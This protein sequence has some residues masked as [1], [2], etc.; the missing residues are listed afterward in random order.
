[1]ASEILSL[2]WND[3]S[4]SVCNSYRDLLKYKDFTN[5]TLATDDDEQIKSHKII[6]SSCSKFF[7]RIL[8]K[9]PHENPLIYLKGAKMYHLKLLM[10]FIYL[11]EVNI[12]NEHVEAF[13]NLAKDLEIQ[14]LSGEENAAGDKQVETPFPD[15]NHESMKKEVVIPIYNIKKEVPEE[16]NTL[17]HAPDKYLESNKAS[18]FNCDQCNFQTSW[19]LILE[20]H[21]RKRHQQSRAPVL[22]CNICWY[23]F[24]SARDLKAHVITTHSTQPVK[25][26]LPQNSSF[27]PVNRTLVRIKQIRNNLKP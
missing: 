15:V 13:I 20:E 26:A 27:S 22:T 9:N 24:Q 19:E 4:T 10:Q 6:L 14:G 18:E 5:V 8:L 17:N 3:Y 16:I 11:G 7:R 25:I 21:K 1:M 12:E 23:T 2:T